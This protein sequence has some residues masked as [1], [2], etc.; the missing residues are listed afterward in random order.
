MEL[1]LQVDPS[2]QATTA[3]NP[4]VV[5]VGETSVNVQ[6]L[7]TH[8]KEVFPARVALVRIA[9][10][11]RPIAVVLRDTLLQGLFEVKVPNRTPAHYVLTL[12]VGGK[13]FQSH[14]EVSVLRP[15]TTRV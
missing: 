13:H 2:S 15:L 5:M 10:T 11:G 8:R 6:R 14:I 3:G 7:R 9:T 4:T 1:A 12:D